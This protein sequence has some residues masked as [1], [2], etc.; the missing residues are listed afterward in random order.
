MGKS[1]GKGI[2]KLMTFS[3]DLEEI[4]GMKKGTRGD[5]GAAIWDYILGPK[6]GKAP[7]KKKDKEGNKIKDER[8]RDSKKAHGKKDPKNGQILTISGDEKLMKI[9]KK[10]LGQPTV[11]EPKEKKD[12]TKTKRRV[13]KPTKEQITMFAIG[14][15]VAENLS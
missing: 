11:F 6:I 8:P 13:V 1:E 3:S 5:A 14:S 10:Y 4:T 2:N 15:V 7:A 9:F 12:G